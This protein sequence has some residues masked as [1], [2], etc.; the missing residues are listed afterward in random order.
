MINYEILAFPKHARIKNKKVLNNKKHRCEFCK[1]QCHTHSHH[2]KT[3]G[4][5]GD[6]TEENIIELCP[7]CHDLA[8]RGKI[9]RQWLEAIKK[10]E[11]FYE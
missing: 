10:G 3:K 7:I 6:D 2:I 1:K 4:S 9:K 8:H 5:G 11:E